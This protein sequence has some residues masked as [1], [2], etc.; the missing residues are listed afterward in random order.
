[1]GTS[2]VMA[3]E[4]G[5]RRKKALSDYERGHAVLKSMLGDKASVGDLE[6]EFAKL[7]VLY[8]SLVD[9]QDEYTDL[10]TEQE[11]RRDGDVT[12]VPGRQLGECKAKIGKYRETAVKEA[13]AKKK[14]EEEA[15]AKI[16][17]EN[18]SKV[19]CA[20]VKASFDFS[21]ELFS[22][23]CDGVNDLL[24]ETID[25]SVIQDE[26][27]KLTAEK[28]RLTDTVRKIVMLDPRGES[29]NAVE[30]RTA[31]KSKVTEPYRKQF[32][33]AQAFLKTHTPAVIGDPV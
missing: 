25:V 33:L 32:Q 22:D 23:M 9:A 24:L 31:M 26:L 14:K 6:T 30:L 17:E 2:E 29:V 7:E 27:N 11:L 12:I 19:E 3:A 20:S 10:A 28:D 18:R 8:Q 21:L 4:A 16:V 13:E 15:A 5:K 1:M